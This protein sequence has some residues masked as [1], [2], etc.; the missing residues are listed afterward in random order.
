MR[1]AL[2]AVLVVIGSGVF[3]TGPLRQLIE[4]YTDEALLDAIA[5]ERSK[6][7]VPVAEA[8]WR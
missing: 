5:V 1:I 4:R 8:S 6:L 3:K 7:E 2:I